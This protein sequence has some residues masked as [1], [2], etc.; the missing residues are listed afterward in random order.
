MYKSI[1]VLM[2]V[3]VMALS[4]CQSENL[5][6][7]EEIEEP[8]IV[9]EKPQNFEEKVL[10]EKEKPEKK[11]PAEEIILVPEEEAEKLP[12]I[13]KE[14]EPMAK[15]II[16]IDTDNSDNEPVSEKQLEYIIGFLEEER[17][18]KADEI[19][20]GKMEFAGTVFHCSNGGFIAVNFYDE[21]R[22]FILKK[23]GEGQKNRAY[24]FAP[25]EAAEFAELFRLKTEESAKTYDRWEDV[26]KP[27]PEYD[28]R[29]FLFRFRAE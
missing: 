15:D 4:S 27:Y 9:F 16:G 21:E 11:E 10:P 2:I 28:E 5:T 6:E 8:G 23:W 14:D 17:W 18:E 24:Y 7:A 20:N 22:A 29:L 1:F 3:L 26:S 19:E 13:S 25:K 12:E